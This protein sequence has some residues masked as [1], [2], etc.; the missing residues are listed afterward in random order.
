MIIRQSWLSW[1]GYFSVTLVSK[2]WCN[3]KSHWVNS[4]NCNCDIN[5]LKDVQR[6]GSIFLSHLLIAH[7]VSTTTKKYHNYI[8]WSECI[9]RWAFSME[10]WSSNDWGFI[11]RSFGEISFKVDAIHYIVGLAISFHF[12]N[13]IISSLLSTHLHYFVN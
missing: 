7:S 13:A 10:S 3:R 1:S 12:M 2:Q 4:G 5:E 8:K 9:N 6:F 11:F